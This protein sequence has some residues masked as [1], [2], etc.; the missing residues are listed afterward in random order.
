MLLPTDFVYDVQV[1]RLHEYK[2][3]LMNAFSILDIYYSI[4]DGTLT[5][6]TP[7]AFIFGAKAAPGY[8]RAKNIIKFINEIANMVNSDPA[9]KDAM[10]VVFVQN[11]NCSYAEM[12]IPAADISEQI[13]PAGTEASGTG[14]M[15]LMLNG[16]VTLGT[17]DG[18]NI[19]IAEQAGL[20]NNYIFG[21]TV[22]DIAKYAPPT[23]RR[24][25]T[26]P[27]PA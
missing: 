26:N 18:A 20:E 21:A 1:K 19:E 3:Q 23:T 9:M 16:A 14:N 11:Y 7:T 4:K 5:D 22:E 10:R 27:T 12:I 15:K 24:A 6:F 17:Y 8:I 13:S 2:R 25:Y